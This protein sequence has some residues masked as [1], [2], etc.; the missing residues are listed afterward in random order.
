MS[1]YPDSQNFEQ[2]R[3]LLALKRHEQPPPG[4]FNSF[5]A[6]V[7]AR[8]KAGERG[9]DTS[10]LWQLFWEGNWLQKVWSA[11]ESKP[12]LAG[13]FGVMVCGLLLSGVI[14]SGTTTNP[15]KFADNV[16][17]VQPPEPS[18]DPDHA[19]VANAF[20]DD[21]IMVQT[22][23]SSGVLV[24]LQNRSGSLFEEI[25][26]PEMQNLLWRIPNN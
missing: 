10:S 8:I 13:A 15:T 11:M 19:R 25:R 6:Q 20:V 2:L 3:R 1:M 22:P 12:A 14:Y 7:I 23:S 5:S 16:L 21:S 17:P 26:K 18:P 4:Y 24:S 9:E